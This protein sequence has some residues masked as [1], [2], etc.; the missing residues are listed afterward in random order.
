MSLGAVTVFS[1][2][3]L[4]GIWVAKGDDDDAAFF[5]ALIIIGGWVGTLLHHIF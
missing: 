5:L 2:V 1:A 3:A 4:V